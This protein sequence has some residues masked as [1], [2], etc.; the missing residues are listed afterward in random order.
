MV[1][2]EEINHYTLI[3]NNDNNYNYSTEPTILNRIRYISLMNV[4]N[5]LAVIRKHS[6]T[7]LIINDYNPK[8]TINTT[9]NN[10]SHYTKLPKHV[11]C[12]NSHKNTNQ[13]QKRKHANLEQPIIYID[14]SSKHCRKEWSPGKYQ[15]IIEIVDKHKKTDYRTI[16]WKPILCSWK[17]SFPHDDMLNTMNDEDAITKLRS[18][19]L[20]ATRKFVN[21]T[22]NIYNHNNVNIS[23]NLNNIQCSSNDSNING[24]VLDY[25]D[26]IDELINNE[27]ININTT[28]NNNNNNHLNELLNSNNQINLRIPSKKQ[29]FSI[30]EQDILD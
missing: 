20:T 29:P 24:I 7:Q 11:S 8:A 15:S 30:D 13:N 5:Y 3:N 26:D 19:H 2:F 22:N 10:N 12:P 17:K 25:N 1:D 4:H 9:S 28:D 14:T 23:N 18:L 6:N 16:D 21:N 27:V